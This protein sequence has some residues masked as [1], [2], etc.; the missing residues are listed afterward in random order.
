MI[1]EDKRYTAALCDPKLTDIRV[2]TTLHQEE[3]SEVFGTL[4]AT[5]TGYLLDFVR[6]EYEELRYLP[7][8]E[9]E[10]AALLI[11]FSQAGNEDH[12]KCYSKK[13]PA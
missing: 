11:P 8:R 6:E 2:E 4:K 10:D 9:E 3:S 12:Q 5:V 1:R 13:H 7:E